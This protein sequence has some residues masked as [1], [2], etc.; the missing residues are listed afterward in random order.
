MP[1]AEKPEQLKRSVPWFIIFSSK[2]TVCI[3]IENRISAESEKDTTLERFKTSYVQTKR[4]AQSMIELLK[5]STYNRHIIAMIDTNFGLA[6][7]GDL[8]RED[9]EKNDYRPVSSSISLQ[10]TLEKELGDKISI[11]QIDT[12]S[13]YPDM[14]TFSEAIGKIIRE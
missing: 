4:D 5:A 3:A 9:P 10:R 14:S 11:I 1:S 13:G 6:E 7:P 12:K 8:K 2:K